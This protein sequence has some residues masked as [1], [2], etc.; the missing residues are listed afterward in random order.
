MEGLENGEQI[1]SAI[2]LCPILR[3]LS[4]CRSFFSQE[5]GIISS[6]VIWD[7]YTTVELQPSIIII[8]GHLGH[9]NTLPKLHC[10]VQM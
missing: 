2:H 5:E 8:R 1:I 4:I 10:A 9:P 7:L 3:S 6:G